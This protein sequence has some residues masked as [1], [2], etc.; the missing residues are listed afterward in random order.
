MLWEDQRTGTFGAVFGFE[1][2][3]L[4]PLPERG[5]A[6]GGSLVVDV[7]GR[8]PLGDPVALAAR[9]SNGEPLAALGA[10]FDDLGDGRGQLRWEPDFTQAGSYAF[11]VELTTVGGLRTARTLHVQVA[12][13]NRPPQIAVPHH[14]V[15]RVG[16][17]LVLDACASTDPDGDV[18]HFAWRDASGAALGSDCALTLPARSRPGRVRVVLELSDGLATQQARV[19]ARWL[20]GP[21]AAAPRGRR[22][23]RGG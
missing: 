20:P 16:Q 11:R 22:G 2:P 18:L 3:S 6:E 4:D 9:Q 23:A 19:F 12:D 7:A 17:A 5:V 14:P 10:V 21:A 15:A 13:V 1:L 8:D